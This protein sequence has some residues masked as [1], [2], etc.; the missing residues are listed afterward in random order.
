[1]SMDVV[2][3]IDYYMSLGFSAKGAAMMYLTRWRPQV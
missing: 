2:D 1:M 3:W